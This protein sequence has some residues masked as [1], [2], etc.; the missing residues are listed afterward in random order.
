MIYKRLSV[1]ADIYEGNVCILY[2]HK[3]EVLCFER[4]D[5][6]IKGYRILSDFI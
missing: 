5:Y 2:E 1:R 4:D 3:K 6:I